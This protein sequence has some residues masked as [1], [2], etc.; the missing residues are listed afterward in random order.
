MIFK[1][2]C[3][4]RFGCILESCQH[5]AFFFSQS[6]IHLSK[7][8]TF[9]FEFIILNRLTTDANDRLSEFFA[10]AASVCIMASFPD[11]I[12]KRIKDNVK[13]GMS[14]MV[15][16]YEVRDRF[17]DCI[18]LRYGWVWAIKY[19]NDGNRWRLSMRGSKKNI[20]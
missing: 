20:K 11:I 15:A 10:T 18:R 4:D 13:L 9:Y 7:S 16:V 6:L 5:L 19:D 17:Y 8:C 14:V 1:A 2:R 3:S 12:S